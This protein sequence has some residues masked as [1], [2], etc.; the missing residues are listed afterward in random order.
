MSKTQK[1]FVSNNE[2]T[3]TIA[4]VRTRLEMAAND[5]EC[6]VQELS[7]SKLK[8]YV[9]ERQLKNL[10]GLP[11]IKNA[12][13]PMTEK[14]LGSIKKAK[15]EKSYISKLED[16]V[17]SQEFLNQEL[18][19]AVKSNLKPLPKIKFAKIKNKNNK[20]KV[21]VVGMLNDTHIGVIV[22]PEEINGANSFDF[23]E[24]CRRFAFYTKEVA[25]Y[26]KDKRDKVTKL[27]LILNGDLIAGLIHGLSTKGIHLMVHQVNAAVHIFTH[28]IANLAPEFAEI[29]VHG[30]AGNHCRAIHKDHGRAVNEVYDSYA[31]L[32]FYSLSVAFRNN[33]EISFNFPKTPYGFINLPAG[34]AMFAHGDHIFSKALG[35]PGSSIN[36]KSLTNAIRDFNNGLIIQ[37]Q[38][39]V[40]LIMFAHVHSFAHFITSDGVE[41]YIAPSL[42]GLDPFAHSL[43][44]NNNFIAQVVFESTK[45]FI[46]GDSR[47]VRLNS[48]D[49]DEELDKI[50]PVYSKELKW[51]K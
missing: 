20:D 35:N 33:K 48:A 30:L 25:N 36:V 11:L 40:K 37:G 31:N 18:L 5:L 43:T 8:G 21:E 22:D 41:V 24:A 49:K 47:L 23:K 39:P 44:I 3:L 13:Y 1:K 2:K 10:G 32:I 16:R 4:E 51:Q 15:I 50:I 28:V 46:L 34:R 6:S 19:D 7:V 29:E 27:H 38:E 12:Y 9:S 17:A 42:I 26:K 45:Q 14:E